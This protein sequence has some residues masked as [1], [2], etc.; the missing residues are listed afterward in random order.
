MGMFIVNSLCHTNRSWSRCEYVS[1]LAAHKGFPK[2]SSHHPAK[3]VP[4]NT[5]PHSPLSQQGS[6]AETEQQGGAEA[7]S[8]PRSK[9]SLNT[10]DLLATPSNRCSPACARSS[11]TCKGRDKLLG[12]CTDRHTAV[13]SC[14]QQKKLRICVTLR[15]DV[16][17]GEAREC[18]GK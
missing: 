6:L 3:R 14:K 11:A 16:W 13:I 7:H 15:L 2:S 4:A 8:L 10:M 9:T 1:G 17:E 12:W 18:L 5:E